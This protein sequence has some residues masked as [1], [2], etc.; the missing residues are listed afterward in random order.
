MINSSG[1]RSPGRARA[2][3]SWGL[4]NG[5]VTPRSRN[6]AGRNDSTG[7][8]IGE[9]VIGVVPLMCRQVGVGQH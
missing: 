3:F 4:V 1:A 5:T 8:I 7:F 2:P 6:V 9:S